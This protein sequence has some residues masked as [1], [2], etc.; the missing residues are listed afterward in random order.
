[1]WTKRKCSIL[2]IQDKQS[3]ILGLEKGEKGTSL[4]SEYG[5]SK[6]QISDIH[7]NKDKIMKF[8]DNL[9]SDHGLKRKFS[10]DSLIFIF[11]IIQTLDYPDYSGQSPRVRIIEVRLYYKTCLHFTIN[12]SNKLIIINNVINDLMIIRNNNNW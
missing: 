12:D 2:T 10:I 4:S 9:E 6:Q 11:S 3:I 7:K 1:M 8:A 5:V